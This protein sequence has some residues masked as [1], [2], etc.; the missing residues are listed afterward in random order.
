MKTKKFASASRVIG[1]VLVVAVSM[2]SATGIAAAETSVGLTV[3]SSNSEKAENLE[4]VATLVEEDVAAVEK[5]LRVLD[6]IPEDVLERGDQATMEW[7]QSQYATPLTPD[8]SPYA[9]NLAKCS[10][11]VAAA[12]GSNTIAVLKVIKIKRAI[13]KMGGVGKII[14]KIQG[15]KKQGKK[16]K[17][18][19]FEAFE[20]AGTG[21]GA[22]AAEILGIDG[23]INNCW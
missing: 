2:G 20:E 19:L 17:A 12:I 4:L 7:I 8:S 22:L 14:A 23:V 3:S 5:V 21:M 18:A 10:V 16:F 11:G 6:A 13:D 9:F 15:K 1:A